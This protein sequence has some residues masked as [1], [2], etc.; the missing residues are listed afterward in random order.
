LLATQQ[1]TSN[2]WPCETRLEFKDDRS[3]SMK[4]WGNHGSSKV[5]SRDNKSCD[6]TSREV[7]DKGRFRES[8]PTRAALLYNAALRINLPQD[9]DEVKRRIGNL[10]LANKLLFFESHVGE[11]PMVNGHGSEINCRFPYR[12]DL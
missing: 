4:I 7:K 11:Q 12:V 2:F 9:K 6:I 5:G 8:E 10:N 1:G 3:G